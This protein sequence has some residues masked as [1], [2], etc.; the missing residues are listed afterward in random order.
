MANEQTL[1][2]DAIDKVLDNVENRITDARLYR[3][4]GNTVD[5][6]RHLHSALAGIHQ[7]LA[8]LS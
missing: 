7:A 6:E 3:L 4:D 1:S 2:P 8:A 5:A